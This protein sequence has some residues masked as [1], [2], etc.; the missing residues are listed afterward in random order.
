[1]KMRPTKKRSPS[2]PPA[3]RAP[4]PASP[5]KKRRLSARITVATIASLDDAVIS[6]LL[7]GRITSWNAAAGDMFGYTDKEANGRHIS[8]IIPDERLEE[9]QLI[10][11]KI[12]RGERVH[13]YETFRQRR[14]GTLLPISLTVS[15]LKDGKGR[16]VGIVK[17]ARDIS[18]Q[19]AVH[20]QLLNYANRL[21]EP[22]RARTHSLEET[23]RDLELTRDRLNASLEKE[24]EL[25]L[26]KSRFVSIASH[27]FRTPL[28]SIK[29]SASLAEKYLAAEASEKAIV[30]LKKIEAAVGILNGILEEFLS[31][32]RLENDKVTL[33]LTTFDLVKFTEAIIEEMKDLA[34]DGQQLTYAHSGDQD[35][36]TL[37]RSLLHNCLINLLSNAIKYSPPGM[38]VDC[39]T[40]ITETG[41]TITVSDQGIG[42]P[43][44]DQKKLF[45][46]F[47]RASNTSGIQ[48]TG[49][50]LNIVS[51]YVGMMNGAISFESSSSGTTFTLAFPLLFL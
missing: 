3:V 6:T 20:T 15:A 11:D 34:K 49:L 38:R 17:V 27:E 39:R 1:M 22:V 31:L 18:G 51:R 43:L 19:V 26:L 41:C 46:A 2:Q 40:A 7:D 16:I 23:V 36:V 13:H 24:K 47:F 4:Q 9:E 44:V 29:L 48:G 32:E 33:Q 21:E 10:I 28:A 5:R 35:G 8:L 14:D 12:R 45:S 30:H 37:D 25:S 42:I 50:G